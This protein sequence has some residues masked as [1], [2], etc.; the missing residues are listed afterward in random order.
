MPLSSTV[1][2]APDENN[3]EDHIP[4]SSDHDQVEEFYPGAGPGTSMDH[5]PEESAAEESDAEDS[6]QKS[7]GLPESRQ[8]AD[9][10]D[11]ETFPEF[12]W[13][14]G[15]ND[16]DL[17]F[18]DTVDGCTYKPRK[19]WCFLAE[20]IDVDAFLRLRLTVRDKAGDTATVAFYT[21]GRGMEFFTQLQQGNTVAIL[22]AERHGFL[23]LTAG[24][25][26]EEEQGIKARVRFRLGPGQA[27]YSM[28]RNAN[29][30]NV[31]QIIPASL[32]E[33]LQLS[34]RIRQYATE[35][36]GKR[37]CHGCGETKSKTSLKKCG[38]CSLFWY[39]NKSCQTTG[40][41]DRGHKHDCKLLQDN[42]LRAM[43]LLDW[44]DFDDFIR[45]PLDTTATMRS[46]AKTAAESSER[47]VGQ[48]LQSMRAADMEAMLISAAREAEFTQET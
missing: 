33:L 22:Y 34:D 46:G 19:H 29:K 9:L 45:F 21:D 44:D 11:E 39:C 27:T 8:Y 18:Y 48:G 43:F 2:A 13:L 26:Q 47:R 17:V 23:D 36:D 4:G 38:R 5:T 14:P 3:S 16:V 42:D 41:K 25:R 1:S 32:T 24:I 7:E 20:I 6:V 37:N 35:R 28:T 31:S 30:R 12:N 10:R 40:W 15:E